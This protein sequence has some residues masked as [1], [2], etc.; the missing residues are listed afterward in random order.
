M[1]D[2]KSD[3]DRQLKEL[4]SSLKKLSEA[5]TQMTAE[6]TKSIHEM[7]LKVKSMKDSVQVTVA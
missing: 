3:Y 5:E 1:K 6:W 4:E 2:T 7:E